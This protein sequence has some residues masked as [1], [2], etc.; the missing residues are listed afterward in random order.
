MNNREQKIL[1]YFNQNLDKIQKG[2]L[3]EGVVRN[4]LKSKD[5]P[6]LQV[7]LLTNPS[8]NKWELL[9]V[10]SVH[11]F[12]PEPFYGHGLSLWQKKWRLNLYNDKDIEPYLFVYDL[13]EKCIYYNSLVALD[14][15]DSS[16]RFITK[17]NI[18]I[19]EI[20]NFKKI[21]I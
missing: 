14:Q 3:G 2:Y 9:E 7:D 13:D 16:L 12:T 4:Y 21:T 6:H 19:F 15:L 5:I 1:K 17:N 18:E 20:S 8:N 10:K 11:K